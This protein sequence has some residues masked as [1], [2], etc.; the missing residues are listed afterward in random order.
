MEYKDN[1]IKYKKKYLEL[2]KSIGGT[3]EENNNYLLHG[4]S[5]YYID[6]IIKN[7][8]TGLYNERI[9][10]IIKKYWNQIRY[11][12]YDSYVDDFIGRQDKRR[13]HPKSRISLSFT[14]QSSVAEEYSIG[15][16]QFGEGPSRFIS[17]LQRYIADKDNKDKITEEMKKDLNFLLDASRFPGIILAINKDEFDET[18]RWNISYMDIWE[19]TL[20]VEIPADKLYIRKGW[21]DYIE[22]L[23]E[24][25]KEY[26]R[27]KKESFYEEREEEKREEEKSLDEWEIETRKIA[28]LYFY[29]LVNKK[30]NINIL[31]TYDIFNENKSPHYL[32]IYITNYSNISI[33]VTIKHKLKEL[34]ELTYETKTI[35]MEGYELYNKNIELKDK[36]KDAIKG[37]QESIPPKRWEKIKTHKVT[38]FNLNIEVL[39]IITIKIS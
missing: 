4:T 9:Y 27:E 29:K 1:Y 32:E 39:F 33:K 37:I 20:H 19:E 36:L 17:T 6:D 22:L 34:K 16:R 35:Y 13:S 23:S 30:K 7:G 25:G 28:P 11:K 12:S 31:V 18:R 15:S 2:K 21:N 38:I 10:K 3:K 5:L 14:G 24:E 8:L 26:I